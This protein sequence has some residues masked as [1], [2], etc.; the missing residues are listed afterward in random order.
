MHSQATINANFTLSRN[1]K[2]NGHEPY[3][4]LRHVLTTLP[5]YPPP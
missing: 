3:A 2:I 5:C 1:R 4:W